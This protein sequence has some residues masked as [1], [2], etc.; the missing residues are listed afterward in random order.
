M[1]NSR[2]DVEALAQPLTAFLRENVGEDISIVGG[3]TRLQGGF[4][5]DTYAV[6]I[7][8]APGDF[9][10][11]LV[12]RHFRHAGE[13]P[14]V[15]RESAIQN[16]AAGDGRPVPRVPVDSTGELLNDRPF[17][18][19]ERLPGSNLGDALLKDEGLIQRFPG[20]MATLQ[21]KLHKIDST[22]LRE[23]LESKGIGLDQM[24]P[25]RMIERITGIANATGL[26]DLVELDR[27]LLEHYPEQPENP[28]ICHGDLHP[29]N[30][31]Y[32]DGKITGL[33]DWAT[34]LLSHPE[35]D[36][37]VSRMIL[38]IGPPDDAGIPKEQLD[39]VL[40]WGLDEYMKECHSLQ[41]LDDSLI[42]YYEVLRVSHAYSKIVGK[43]H[44]V[45]L[46]Y[47]AHDGYAWDRADLFA[48][49]TRIIGETTGIELVS[50]V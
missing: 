17:L 42:D 45:D 19:M 46:P 10:Q 33:I 4:D 12:L 22:G 35:Y 43:R 3:L 36:I 25:S 14:R 9:P 38:S 40:A 44:G 18:L 41:Q 27:W 24:Q 30:I 23:H 28:A 2:K 39:K 31:L 26:P 21:A 47:V 49:V 20:I 1:P 37:A 5:T 15:I 13:L 8:N 7:A 34:T 32:D 50:A 11:S 6:E 16:A 48:V 29:N